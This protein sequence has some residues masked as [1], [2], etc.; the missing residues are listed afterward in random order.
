MQKMKPLC[1]HF[2]KIGTRAFVSA[3]DG[4]STLRP[5]SIIIFWKSYQRKHQCFQAPQLEL[6]PKNVLWHNTF[7]CTCRLHSSLCQEYC[8]VKIFPSFGHHDYFYSWTP[9]SPTVV[10][11]SDRL[12]FI[13]SDSWIFQTQIN[14]WSTL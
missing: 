8:S 6:W 9:W 4:N 13:C 5:E 12:T 10:N 14:S 1:G 11:K 3:W 7:F 2:N